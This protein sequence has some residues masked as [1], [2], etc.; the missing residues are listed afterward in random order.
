MNRRNAFLKAVRTTGKS[1]YEL[2]LGYRPKGWSDAY[3]L[4]DLDLEE[5]VSD[6]ASVRRQAAEQTAQHQDAQKKRYDL[7]R[8]LLLNTKLGSMC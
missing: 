2:L 8:N 1:P 4:N 5:N 7:R 6:L 3:L